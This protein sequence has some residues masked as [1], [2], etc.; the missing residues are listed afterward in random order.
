MTDAL[1]SSTSTSSPHDPHAPVVGLDD[2]LERVRL[3]VP[4]A[5]RRQLWTLFFDA[6]DVQL[7]MLVPLDG[8]PELPDGPAVEH[9]GDALDEVAAE[10]G[11]ATVVFVLER[12]GAARPT[13]SDLAWRAALVAL[14]DARRYG[15]RAVVA[16]ATD[17]V[18]V[19]DAAGAGSGAASTVPGVGR[20]S[21]SSPRR[22][23]L[24][25]VLA[26]R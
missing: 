26:V 3:L 25:E 9:W 12:P 11:V 10:F 14:G 18:V 15:V 17:G 22:L 7:P 1:A 24:S 20:R 6:D 13:C 2:L 16:R 21:Q 23:R 5:V 8:V 19:L 4:V